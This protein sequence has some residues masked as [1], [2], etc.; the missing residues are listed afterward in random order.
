MAAKGQQQIREHYLWPDVARSI[1]KAYYK[2]LDRDYT[3]GLPVAGSE[4]PSVA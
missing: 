1:E 3:A 2:V 4:Q